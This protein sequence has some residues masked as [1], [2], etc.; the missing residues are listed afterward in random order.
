MVENTGLAKI[1]F[2]IEIRRNESLAWSIRTELQWPH[3]N[4]QVVVVVPTSVYEY[5]ENPGPARTYEELVLRSAP[6]T[7]VQFKV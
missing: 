5:E 1:P 2:Q 3:A 6:C 4:D 7:V